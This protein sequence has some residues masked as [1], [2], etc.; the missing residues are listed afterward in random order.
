[1][2]R[3]YL[4]YSVAREPV[5]EDF[6]TATGEGEKAKPLTQEFSAYLL[7]MHLRARGHRNN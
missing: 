5:P 7:I 6:F 2:E 3:R 1:M 4:L